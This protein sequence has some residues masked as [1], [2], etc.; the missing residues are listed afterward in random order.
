VE[1]RLD[2]APICLER[3]SPDGGAFSCRTGLPFPAGPHR[4]VAVALDEAGNSSAEAVRDFGISL[5]PPPAPVVL[6][7]AEGAALGSSQVEVSGRA[8]AE[9]PVTVL[10]DQTAVGTTTSSPDG[11]FSLV[12][13]VADGP[14][15][16]TAR[17][18]EDERPSP[19]SAPV[20]FTVDTR[21]PTVSLRFTPQGIT[22]SADE[23]QVTFSCALD[24]GEASPC[25]SPFLLGMLTPGTYRLTV[26]GTDAAGNRSPPTQLAFA[27]VRDD[28]Q[29]TGCGCQAGGG[30]GLLLLGAAL[31][32]RRRARWKA[33]ASAP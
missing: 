14:H 15:Q 25:S 30:P 16:V 29:P 8:R 13:T 12:A 3:V 2:G 7:P 23:P 5:D 6:R 17:V 20:R 24:M 28:P 21:A 33:T 10:I 18:V 22:L 32:S 31:L 11:G 1:V 4:A 27:L 9:L 19:E 26:V